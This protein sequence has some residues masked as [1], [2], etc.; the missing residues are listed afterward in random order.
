MIVSAEEYLTALDGW[1]T[2]YIGA[3][4]K[5]GQDFAFCERHMNS[6]L[7]L[8]EDGSAWD[9]AFLEPGAPSPGK[10]WT[11]YRLQGAAPAPPVLPAFAPTPPVV[12]RRRPGVT[13]LVKTLFGAGA[14]HPH[15]RPTH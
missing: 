6:G 14:P 13:D 7:Q 9:Y 15:S 2:R 12:V 1:L 3:A 11:V 10:A 8:D 5:A 4:T